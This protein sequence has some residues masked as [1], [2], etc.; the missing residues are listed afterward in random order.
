MEKGDL[1]NEVVP[2]LLIEFEGLLAHLVVQEPEPPGFMSRML[3]RRPEP[4]STWDLDDLVVKVMWDLTYR[5]HQEL[6]VI[7]KQGQDFARELAERLDV[8][9]V[10]ARRVW[11]YEPRRLARQLAAMP[12]VAAVY[13]G[14]LEHA[15]LYG[16]RGRLITPANVLQMGRF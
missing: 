7:T 13:T 14:E 5:F 16:S 12:Y 10:P 2:R 1:G 3:G 15:M 4:V 9:Q 8:E 11:A 6:D